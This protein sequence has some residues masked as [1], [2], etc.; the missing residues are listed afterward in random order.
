MSLARRTLEF[1]SLVFWNDNNNVADISPSNNP[2]I[3]VFLES[4]IL[5]NKPKL[6]AL[7]IISPTPSDP[8]W[9]ITFPQTA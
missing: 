4:Q 1:L 3:D 5:H 2:T 6:L 8:V 9:K 7:K